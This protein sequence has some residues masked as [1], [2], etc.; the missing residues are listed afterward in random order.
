M[1]TLVEKGGM[2]ARCVTVT[3]FGNIVENLSWGGILRECFNYVKKEEK[4]REEIPVN[5]ARL[6][7]WETNVPN[8]FVYT[9]Q[10]E[11]EVP[12][13]Q[14]PAVVSKHSLWE[15]ENIRGCREETEKREGKGKDEKSREKRIEIREKEK[16]L[17]NLITRADSNSIG[18][19][20][21]SSTLFSSTMRAW[22]TPCVVVAFSR[23]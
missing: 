6:N 18:S 11:P 22:M 12:V 15:D 21:S 17:S 10:R 14:R 20:L 23:R 9:C 1:V 19:T 13:K 2:S 5:K 8:N 3:L 16:R 4:N 7:V